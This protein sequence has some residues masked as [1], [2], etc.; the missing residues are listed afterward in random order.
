VRVYFKFWKGS[1]I[2]MANGSFGGG[3]G[4]SGDPYLIEDIF[5]LIAINND[6]SKYYKL[7]NDIDL[8]VYPYNVAPGW[9]P[10]YT[11]T[12]N[13]DGNFHTI[14]NLFIERDT[15]YQGLFSNM[16]GTFKNCYLENFNINYADVSTSRY[17]HMGAISGQSTSVSA[18]VENVVVKG[19]KIYGSEYIGGLF[20][21]SY[22]TI[23]N[24]VV[25]DFEVNA[26]ADYI[27][28]VVGYKYDGIING[29]FV[30]NIRVGAGGSTNAGYYGGVNEYNRTG[31]IQ[32]AYFNNTNYP[33]SG[34]GIGYNNTDIKKS[35]N[36]VGVGV[37]SRLDDL[38]NDRNFKA[39]I[40]DVSDQDRPRLFMEKGINRTTLTYMSDYTSLVNFG[41]VVEGQVSTY[42]KVNVKVAYDIPIQNVDITWE[43]KLDISELTEIEFSLDQDFTTP[44]SELHFT[45]LNLQRGD[46]ITFYMRIKTQVGMS[47]DGQFNLYVDVSS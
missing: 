45:S 40:V 16:N 4:L 22:A 27:A 30:D 7:V 47:G 10:L 9:I 6:P 20:G 25:D 33:Y 24:C 21:Y 32:N 15:S 39:W 42:R 12:G 8:N 2:I 44:T 29:V 34:S 36:Y 11:F 37:T 31:A 17:S 18:L 5:D 46:E 1:E 43:R 3:T 19:L 13:F 41:A 23:K 38:L 35:A 14:Y 28:G 26:S